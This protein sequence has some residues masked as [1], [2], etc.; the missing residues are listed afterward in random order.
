MVKS[1]LRVFGVRVEGFEGFVRGW[2]SLGWG[3]HCCGFGG[4]G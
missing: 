4:C 2:S 3:R 1:R